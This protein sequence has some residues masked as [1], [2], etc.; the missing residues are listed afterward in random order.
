MRTETAVPPPLTIPTKLLLGAILLLYL[1]LAVGYSLLNPLFEAPDEH[2]HYFTA[3]YIADNRRLPFVADDYDEWLS[4]EAAQPPLYYVAGALLIAP[5]NTSD[6]PIAGGRDLLWLNPFAAIG[7]ASVQANINR[8]VHTPAEQWPWQ[9]FALAAHT[10]RL[11]SILLGLG[12]LLCIYGSGRLVWPAQ[13]ERAL[14]ATAVVAFLPQFLFLHSAI[15]NDALIIFLCSATLWQLLWLWVKGM[16]DGGMPDYRSPITD[17]QLREKNGRLRYGRLLL[18]GITIG[19]AILTKNAGTLL[20]LYSLGFL[21]L[22]WLRDR[23]RPSRICV[24]L[25][26]FLAPALLMGGWLWWR[27]WLLYG[28][29]T[30]TAPFIR[31]AGGD[32][33]YTLWQ[34]LA[35]S[36]GLWQSLFAIFGWFNVRPPEWLLW[37]WNGIV[38]AAIVGVLKG[39]RNWRLE[40]KRTLQSP[41]SNLQ[42]QSFI[43]VLLLIW[44]LAVYAGLLAFMMKT[45]A[46]QGRLLF[47]AILPLSLGLAY[48]LSQFR[49]RFVFWGVPLLAWLTAVYSLFFVIAPAYALPPTV[50]TLPEGATALD[51]DLGQGLQLVGAHIE[52]ATAVPNDKIW[53][54]LYWQT[55]GT[56]TEPL[57]FVLEL[58]GRDLTRIGNLHSYHGR[59]L[60]PA[61]LWPVDTIIAD[62]FAVPVAD[63]AVAPVMAPLFV[64]LADETTRVRL[65]EIK[66]EPA[67]WPKVAAAPLAQ[68]GDAIW[69]TQAQPETTIAQPGES[70]TVSVQWQTTAIPNANYTTLI[71]LG[72]AGQPPLAT[73][74]NQ[75]V[76]G[77]FPTTA[78]VAGE[79]INDQYTLTIP[80]DLPNGRYPLWIGL[81]DADSLIR[82]PL[83]VDGRR[84]TNDV[85]QIG[86]LVIGNR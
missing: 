34:V 80:A 85:L 76:A 19:L 59:G 13:P 68:L 30:A 17:Y 82:L 8:F 25:L 53:L 48:G 36:G 77:Q 56:A 57:E 49:R 75:P 22:L 21:S 29:P 62:R 55:D 6:V 69:L 46:A 78:W 26:L 51:A 66:I 39:F 71:H 9:G 31:L 28:D 40:I 44:V 16:G 38:L 52:T 72:T 3:Q 32:R 7:D 1:L 63:T 15:T 23:E 27:N 61:T 67:N 10:L 20:L 60:Y 24:S 37:L 81:Y 50:T 65:G 41:I 70:I 64:G 12:T 4:Q 45:E 86:E 79:V 33:G 83:M 74:D 5:I 47:P 54:T 35:E 11:F 42:K 73:G 58:L 43:A 84:Q 2:W 14:L 18:L